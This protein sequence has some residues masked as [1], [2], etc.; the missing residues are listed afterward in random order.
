MAA[1]LGRLIERIDQLQIALQVV[2]LAGGNSRLRRRLERIETLYCTVKVRGFDSSPARYLFAANIVLGKAGWLSLVEAAQCDR[3]TLIVD[4]LPG[5]EA[6][7]VAAAIEFGWVRVI[8]GDVEAALQQALER[9]EGIQDRP[10][11]DARRRIG[12]LIVE[13]LS[14]KEGALVE[15]DGA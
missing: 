6:H 7:N 4:S 2:V 13:A 1:R 12:E 8:S 14:K 10:A 3:P 9:E 5:Q 15:S 11:G